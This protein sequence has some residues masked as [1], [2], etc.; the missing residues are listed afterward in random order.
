M[1]EQ[2]PRRQALID[3]EKGRPTNANPYKKGTS[4]HLEYS[5]E[6]QRQLNIELNEIRIAAG[7]F[8]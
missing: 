3:Y 2:T 8:A 7:E 5:S 1:I 6:M 4:A